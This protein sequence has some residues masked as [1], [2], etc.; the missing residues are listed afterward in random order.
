MM[1]ISGGE[2][3]MSKIVS[4]K[5]VVVIEMCIYSIAVAPE[6]LVP[7]VDVTCLLGDTVILQCRVCGRPKPTITWKGPDQNI[8][9]TDNGSATSTIS[10]W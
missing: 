10:S 2:N 3:T 5:F 9:D 8:L 4:C 1:S 6:F 7:L